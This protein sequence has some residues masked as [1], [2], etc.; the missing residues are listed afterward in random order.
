MAKGDEKFFSCIRFS[1][2]SLRMW[3]DIFNFKIEPI[4][5]EK[6][7][8]QTLEPDFYYLD[9]MQFISSLNWKK[10]NYN[11]LVNES[12]VTFE[13]LE[14]KISEEEQLVAKPAF[15]RL[16]CIDGVTRAC[17][18]VISVHQIQSG[19]ERLTQTNKLLILW[20]WGWEEGAQISAFLSSPNPMKSS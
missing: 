3:V 14:L 12:S 2:S 8:C 5:K 17:S 16:L 10:N 1:M 18:P 19:S 13:R 6:K 15:I 4:S 11:I 7:C 9:F 20:G